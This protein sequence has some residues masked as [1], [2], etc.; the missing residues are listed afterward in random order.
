M[1]YQEGAIRKI[2]KKKKATVLRKKENGKYPKEAV[3]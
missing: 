1:R 2:K 3:A